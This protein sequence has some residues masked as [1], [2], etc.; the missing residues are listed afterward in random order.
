MF[1]TAISRK[2]A[3][4]MAGLLILT[5]LIRIVIPKNDFPAGKPGVEFVFSI[6][7]G[8]TG[9]KIAN[10]L[11]D[12]GV[13]KSPKVFISEFTKN[14]NAQGISPG[15][16]LIHKNIPVKQAVLELLDSKRM[17]N[18]LKVI[19]GSTLNDVIKNVLKNDHILSSNHSL[20]GIKVLYPNKLNSLEG[21]IYPANYSFEK[22]TNFTDALNMMVDR[23]RTS[24]EFAALAKGYSKYNP[25]Q[26][27]TI[28]SMVQIEGDSDSYA[29]VAR[30]IYNRLA[31]GMPLQLNSTVQYAAGLRGKIGLSN[32][33]TQVN[34]PYNTYK[35]TGLP[36]TPIAIAGPKAIE[37]ALNPDAGDWLY[38]IT[39]KPRD[40]RFTK[41]FDEFSK[42]NTEFNNNLANGLFK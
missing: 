6:A 21:S 22:G 9:T 42:W 38:F 10:D 2:V 11:F 40:T 24:V 19:E 14:T 35:V 7:N 3:F 17:A 41:S 20:M 28:A 34:S 1:R 18:V 31:I 8:A 27:L 29:K 39:V 37:A 5:G 25:Y 33:A 26:V 16:H 12:S 15:A 4:L 30:V 32:K 23:F 13:I 36:P